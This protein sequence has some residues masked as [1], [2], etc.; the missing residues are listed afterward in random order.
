[1]WNDY[2]FPI[3]FYRNNSIVDELRSLYDKYNARGDY[4]SVQYQVAVR[5]Q[6]ATDTPTCIRRSSKQQNFEQS[7]INTLCDPYGQFNTIA[8]FPP[9]NNSDPNVIQSAPDDSTV[10]LVVRS[11]A[12][13][14]FQNLASGF[15]QIG[16][17]F[18]IQ[19]AIAKAI[20]ENEAQSELAKFERSVA[21]VTLAGEVWV[22]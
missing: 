10:A 16:I 17:A 9:F 3:V 14:F 19:L 20:S 12:L 18:V 11:D 5:M 1:M 13:S 22:I 2:P 21:L 8:A 4:P 6:A 7:A 15:E